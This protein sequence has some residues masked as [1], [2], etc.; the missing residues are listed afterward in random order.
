[1][2]GGIPDVAGTGRNGKNFSTFCYI[3]QMKWNKEEGS[4][5]EG[6]GKGNKRG[7]YWV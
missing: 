4:T 5:I 1:M 3:L 7:R 6:G 2:R